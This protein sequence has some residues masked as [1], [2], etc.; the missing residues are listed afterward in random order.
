[1]KIKM[2]K[3]GVSLI[4][5]IIIFGNS[6]F[7]FI[8]KSSDF[9]GN[10]FNIERKRIGLETLNKSWNKNCN[11][12]FEKNNNFKIIWINGNQNQTHYSKVT[13][14]GYFGVKTEI[15]SY[16]NSKGSLNNYFSK[17]DFDQKKY[18]YY[19]EYCSGGINICNKISEKEF[20]K[21]IKI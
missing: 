6:L 17:Y 16:R 11:I 7:S 8:V 20:K 10:D 19:T 13:E 15:D 18:E 1:M 21:K 9:Y 4:L 5:I 14:F 12:E 2:I 3:I